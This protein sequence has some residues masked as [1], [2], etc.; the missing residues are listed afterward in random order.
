[1]PL[2]AASVSACTVCDSE[3][4]RR[5]RAAIF[6]EHFGYNLFATLSPFPVFLAVVAALHFG[7]PRWMKDTTG[8]DRSDRT[9]A[10]GD[11]RDREEE[12]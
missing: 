10:G 7:F 1:M 5:L 6:D 12:A 8:G 9:W 11:R 3:N 2:W 4:G